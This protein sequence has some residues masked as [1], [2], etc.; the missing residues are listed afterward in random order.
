MDLVIEPAGEGN[1]ILIVLVGV[2]LS[3]LVPES[4]NF[5]NVPFVLTAFFMELF[6]RLGVGGITLMGVDAGLTWVE[7]SAEVEASSIA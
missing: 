1:E 5:F 6:A 4:F 7:G 3:D 2:P